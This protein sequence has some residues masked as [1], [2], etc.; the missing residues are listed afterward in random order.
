MGMGTFVFNDVNTIIT[1]MDPWLRAQSLTGIMTSKGD[2]H[3]RYL[4]CLLL[5]LLIKLLTNSNL[6]ARSF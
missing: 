2:F 3:F 5:T 4:F 1:S 6:E